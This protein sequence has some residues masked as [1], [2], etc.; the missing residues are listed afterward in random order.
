MGFGRQAGGAG[1]PS[2]DT[3]CA[4]AAGGLVVAAARRTSSAP[5]PL[6]PRAPASR[7]ASRAWLGPAYRDGLLTRIDPWGVF[8]P[9]ILMATPPRHGLGCGPSSAST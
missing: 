8:S 1:L 6:T 7:R 2:P 9:V 5:A 4:A 3:R